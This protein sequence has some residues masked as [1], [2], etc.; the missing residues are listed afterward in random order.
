[1]PSELPMI[2]IRVTGDY[3]D[4]LNAWCAGRGLDVSSLTRLLWDG[5]QAGVISVLPAVV[6]PSKVRSDALPQLSLDGSLR[7]VKAKR[8]VKRKGVRRGA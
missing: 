3:R 4:T 7:P 8:K 5:C 2:T 1:M 6:L